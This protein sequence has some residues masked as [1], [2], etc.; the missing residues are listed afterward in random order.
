[1]DKAIEKIGSFS[2]LSS[3]TGRE[4]KIKTITAAGSDNRYKA[5]KK[6]FMM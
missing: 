1:M 4:N 5:D 6:N 3:I 2:V